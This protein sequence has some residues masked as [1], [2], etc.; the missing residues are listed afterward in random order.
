[1]R[2]LKCLRNIDIKEI[3]LQGGSV[4]NRDPKVGFDT[5]A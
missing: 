5:Y 1:M 3:P 2:A 4:V